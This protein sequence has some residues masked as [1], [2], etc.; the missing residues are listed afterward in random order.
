M[1]ADCRKCNEARVTSDHHHI[2]T[3]RKPRR[4]DQRFE[5]RDPA[6][7]SRIVRVF[8]AIGEEMRR[9]TARLGRPG[10]KTR[11]LADL[12]NRVDAWTWSI[13]SAMCA[14]HP[15][16]GAPEAVPGGGRV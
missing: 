6:L 5:P 3:L 9:L 7:A 13:Q 4:R 8:G 10:C 2:K 16:E 12:L 11:R 14:Y 15:N 1:G